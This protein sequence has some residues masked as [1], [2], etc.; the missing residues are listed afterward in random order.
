LLEAI[1]NRASDIHL[2][3]FEKKFI[4]RM[5]KDG[6]LQELSPPPKEI[7]DAIISRIK[8]M[9]DMDIAESRLPQDGR[10]RI[11]LKG[12]DVDFRV[13]TLPTVFGESVVLRLLSQ[14]DIDLRTDQIGMIPEVEQTYRDMIER[15]NGI[16]LIT[17]PTGC[18]KTTTLYA[19]ITHIND[20]EDK[21]ITMEDPVEYEIPGLIQCQVNEKVGFD[22]ASGMRAILRQDPDICLVGEIRDVETAETA[23]QASLTGHLVL[24][25]THTNEA[26]GAI[27]RLI[28]MGIQPFLLTATLQGVMGQRLVRVICDSCREPY[29]PDPRDVRKLGHDPEEIDFEFVHG[30]G[31]DKCGDTGFDGQTGIFELLEVTDE[32][33]TLINDRASANKIHQQAVEEGMISMHEDGWR[34]VKEGITTVEEVLRVAPVDSS[35]SVDLDELDIDEELAQHL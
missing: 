19:G 13:S 2:E 31:C 6:V 3:P 27:T 12:Q 4:V 26:A 33:K 28:D 15:P 22:F 29:E 16:I 11:Q 30:T 21:I 34:K 32:V 25:T 24:S 14:E 5:R 7:Q 35:V 9:A 1:K 23:V 10:I 17:G 8:V 18:G 20:P